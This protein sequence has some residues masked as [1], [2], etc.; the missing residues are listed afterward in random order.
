M[1][2]KKRHKIAKNYNDYLANLGIQ[3][4]YQ[5]PNTYSSFHLYPIRVSKKKGGVSQKKMYNFLRENMI[6]VNLHYIPIYRQPYFK[7]LG[8]KKDIVLKLKN[9][10]ERL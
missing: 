9:I 1:F 2:V 6:L 8:F 4:P 10:L 5:D 3:L 7:K